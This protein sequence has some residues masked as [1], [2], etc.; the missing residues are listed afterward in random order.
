MQVF[1]ECQEKLP[2]SCGPNLQAPACES[3]DLDPIPTRFAQLEVVCAVQG[4]DSFMQLELHA[5]TCKGHA[6]CAPMSW[7]IQVCF[8]AR[9]KT[10][11]Q[12]PK[13]CLT[14][15]ERLFNQR[16]ECCRAAKAAKSPHRPPQQIMIK[17]VHCATFQHG[18]NANFCVA[19]APSSRSSF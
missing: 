18:V 3:F 13:K 7:C 2:R 14:S 11:T 15:A 17:L 12:C 16:L 6:N 5:R 1:R 9:E 19:K 8:P 10:L 4:A